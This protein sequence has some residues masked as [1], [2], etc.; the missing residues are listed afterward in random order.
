MSDDITCQ[1][2]HQLYVQQTMLTPYALPKYAICYS[3]SI[4]FYN[5]SGWQ[6]IASAAHCLITL[7]IVHCQEFR[8]CPWPLHCHLIRL[9]TQGERPMS[10]FLET[11]RMVKKSR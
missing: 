1:S 6:G 9:W 11:R 7:Q 10:H 2:T 5:Y 3:M 8:C 4:L